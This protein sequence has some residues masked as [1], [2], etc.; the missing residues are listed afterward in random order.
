MT[1]REMMMYD[2]L[3]EYGVVTS[4]ELNLA[5]NMTDNGWSW[6]IDRVLQIRTGNANFDQWLAEQMEEE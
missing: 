5:F 3:V 2:Y 6:T 4:D 1:D